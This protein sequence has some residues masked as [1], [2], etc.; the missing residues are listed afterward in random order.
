MISC[1]AMKHGLKVIDHVLQNVTL[2]TAALSESNRKGLLEEGS[3][4]ILGG[5]LFDWPLAPMES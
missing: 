4:Q 1:S 5:L 2:Q 3:R